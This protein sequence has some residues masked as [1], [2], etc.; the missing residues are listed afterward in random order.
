MAKKIILHWAL[1]SRGYCYTWKITLFFKMYTLFSTKVQ[2]QKSVFIYNTCMAFSSYPLWFHCCPDD[3]KETQRMKAICQF[4]L[5]PSS[6]PIKTVLQTSKNKKKSNTQ[7]RHCTAVFPCSL[8]SL[9]TVP[10]K[11]TEQ[12]VSESDIKHYLC[13]PCKHAQAQVTCQ[14]MSH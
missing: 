2:K 7:Q 8:T 13:L 4:K 11:I 6:W 5:K 10:L 12:C 3:S 9:Q 1:F 14:T